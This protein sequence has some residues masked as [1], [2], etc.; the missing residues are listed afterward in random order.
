MFGNLIATLMTVV[1]WVAER[2]RRSRNPNEE[3]IGS[4]IG[5]L[6]CL[7]SSFDKEALAVFQKAP[8]LRRHC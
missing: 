8:Y 4:P 1:H 7:N 2:A 3:R 6:V 5:N